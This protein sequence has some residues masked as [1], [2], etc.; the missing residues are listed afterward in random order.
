MRDLVG[1][2]RG[3]VLWNH[4]KEMRKAAEKERRRKFKKL[5]DGNL[6]TLPS[7]GSK[8]KQ[9][10]G[11][12]P[13]MFVP[14]YVTMFCFLLFGSVTAFLLTV[15]REQTED[16]LNTK[17]ETIIGKRERGGGGGGSRIPR[18]R[19]GGR[20]ATTTSEDNTRGWKREN[21]PRTQA[22]TYIT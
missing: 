10:A 22:R 7:A 13:L 5:E 20:R 9:K 18:R 6:S 12:P 19:G 11:F 14:S 15:W 8:E 21:R 16:L 4:V 17:R 2:G 1:G 3:V